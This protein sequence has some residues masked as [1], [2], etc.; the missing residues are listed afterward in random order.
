MGRAGGVAPFPPPP[1]PSLLRPPCCGALR[2]SAGCAAPR[3]GRRCFPVPPLASL[4]F[5][6]PELRGAVSPGRAGLAVARGAGSAVKWCPEDESVG[7]SRI[8]DKSSKGSRSADKWSQTTRIKN[9]SSKTPRVVDP[10]SSDK[11]SQASKGPVGYCGPPGLRG[12]SWG[13]PIP[14]C[15]YPYHHFP[16]PRQHPNDQLAHPHLAHLRGS[17]SW[18]GDGSLRGLQPTA[19]IWGGSESA[20]PLLGISLGWTSPGGGAPRHGEAFEPGVWDE[21]FPGP[22]LHRLGGE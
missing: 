4:L 22:R 20:T 1:F 18:C 9:K 2:A 11:S 6:G 19:W 8:E 21:P 17:P 5:A 16:H 10:G 7:A 3:R 12:R 14:P 15:T 13:L